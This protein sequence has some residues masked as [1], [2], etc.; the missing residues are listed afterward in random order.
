M[1]TSAPSYTPPV[2][3]DLTDRTEYEAWLLEAVYDIANQPIAAS[4]GDGLIYPPDGGSPKS[5]VYAFM[6]AI[7]GDWRPKF[8]EVG[9]PL[10]LRYNIQAP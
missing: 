5:I 9:T 6:H 2:I 8:L 7:L 1:S 4:A 10:V 3:A